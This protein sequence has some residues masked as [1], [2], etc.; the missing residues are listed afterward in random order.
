MNKDFENGMKCEHM[1]VKASDMSRDELIAF[2][3]QLDFLVTY[4]GL[5]EGNEPNIVFTYPKNDNA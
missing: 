1:G 5:V 4:W 3:G 2:I